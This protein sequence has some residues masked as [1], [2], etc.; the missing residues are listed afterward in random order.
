MRLNISKW[1]FFYSPNLSHMNIFSIPKSNW[2]ETC[3]SLKIFI[4][5][6]LLERY[7]MG[8]Y[9]FSIDFQHII[10]FLDTYQVIIHIY[11]CN[12]CNSYM[13]WYNLT[14][15]LRFDITCRSQILYPHLEVSPFLLC[16]QSIQFN[17]EIFL[18]QMNRQHTSK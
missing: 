18:V 4:H 2:K 5:L 16:V 13:Y 9:D 11:C 14:L 6:F 10:D 17:S 15:M 12:S 8:K 1:R 7:P 3:N